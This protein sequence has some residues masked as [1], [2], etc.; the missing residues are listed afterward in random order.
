MAKKVMKLAYGSH[1]FV[2]GD[3]KCTSQTHHFLHILNGE[4]T[5]EVGVKS[6][7]KGACI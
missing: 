6:K 3:Y 2:L 4:F 1:H 5:K 7:L